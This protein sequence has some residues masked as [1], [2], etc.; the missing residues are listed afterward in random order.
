MDIITAVVLG[1]VSVS[2]GEGKLG[3]VIIGVVFMG[4]LANG[5]MMMNVSEYWQRVVK[6]IVLLIAVAVDIQAKSKSRTVS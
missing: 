5:M 6:G 2:G 3:K 1:G 4:V